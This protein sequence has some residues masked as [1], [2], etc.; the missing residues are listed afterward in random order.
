ML[1][2]FAL[3]CAT[4]KVQERQVEE[5]VV[6]V[7]IFHQVSCLIYTSHMKMEATGTT[8]TSVDFQQ[9][10]LRYIIEISISTAVENCE[11]HVS[12]LSVVY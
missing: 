9:A 12:L 8:E 4:R 3:E 7:G 5:I 10:A 6:K 2:I 11:P 1:F